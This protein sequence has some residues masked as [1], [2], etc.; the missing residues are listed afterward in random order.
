MR[1]SLAVVA[2]VLTLVGAAGT[3]GADQKFHGVPGKGKSLAVRVV[4][5]DGSVNGTLTVEVRNTSGKAQR[6]SAEGLYFVPDGDPDSA[7]QRLGAVGPLQ[8]ASD[9]GEARSSSVAIPA[10]ATVAV[11]LDVFCIDSHRDAPSSADSFSL[12]RTRMP[13]ALARTIETSAKA[14][15]DD[16]GGYAPAKSSIQ[17]KVWEARDRA[18]IKLDGEGTQEADKA[19]GGHRGPARPQR[20]LIRDKDLDRQAPTSDDLSQPE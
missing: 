17:G 20:V 1:S 7:P 10:G 16:E 6:F 18:W 3:A 13:K 14:A 4:T 19:S 8:L 12:G 9:D 2:L 11:K 5:Y 15:A